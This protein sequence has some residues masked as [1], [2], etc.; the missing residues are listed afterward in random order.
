MDK[1]TEVRK[2]GE[3]KRPVS[4]VNGQPVP[5]SPAARATRFTTGD[6][7]A[8]EAQRKG[9]QTKKERKTL[10]EEL[11]RLLEEEVTSR[12]GEKMQANVA[13]SASM[14]NQAMKGN[15]KAYAII[16]DTIGEKPVERVIVNTPDPDI[17]RNVESVLFGSDGK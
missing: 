11:L 5:D 12:S 3:K 6:P 7:R 13:I 2:T 15:V 1:K 4:P 17:I 9:T 8:R 16:R 10:R 14:I